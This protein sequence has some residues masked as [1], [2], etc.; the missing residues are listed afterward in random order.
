MHTGTHTYAYVY[1]YGY[2]GIY[3]HSIAGKILITVF[4][5]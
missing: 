3:A 4:M 5:R 1:G 2:A